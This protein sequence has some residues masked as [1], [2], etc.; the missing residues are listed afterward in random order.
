MTISQTTIER[1]K[2][3]QYNSRPLTN[4][5]KKIFDNLDEQVVFII[6]KILEGIITIKDLSEAS[7]PITFDSDLLTDLRNLAWKNKNS[8][9]QLAYEAINKGNADGNLAATV[10][11]KLEEI[12]TPE[13][14]K[15]WAE[16]YFSHSETVF[17]NA[18]LTT[19]EQVYKTA[20]LLNYINQG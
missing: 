2:N 20:L 9:E 3:A 12:S 7:S 17:N 14:A 15:T 4:E 16:E 11:Q 6:E 18:L 19:S 10:I 8:Y 13:E 1:A 5:E